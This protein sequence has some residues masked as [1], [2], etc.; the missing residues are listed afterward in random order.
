MIKKSLLVIAFIAAPMMLSEKTADA[1]GGL[2]IGFGAPA[3]GY[4]P[5]YRSNYIGPRVHI[6]RAIPYRP[7]SYYNYS[8]RYVPIQRVYGGSIYGY[9]RSCPNYGY[10]TRFPSYGRGGVSLRIGF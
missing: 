2:S 10:G 6:N 1:H 3:Y 4:S 5:L 7:S 9:G 8:S